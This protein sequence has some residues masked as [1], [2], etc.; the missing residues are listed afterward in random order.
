MIV[1]AS[2]RAITLFH[3]GALAL[4]QV[5][6][7][8]IRVDEA[9]LAKSISRTEKKIRG[10]KE[11]LF[12][13]PIYKKWK[14]RFGQST[15]LDAPEQLAKIIFEDM[16]YKPVKA[17]TTEGRYKADAEAFEHVDEPFVRDLF[18]YKRLQKALT[19]NLRGL[20]REVVDGLVHAI[21]NLN[22]PVSFRSSCDSPNVQNQPVRNEDI[23]NL[24]RHCFIARPG[25]R[26][27][28]IDYGKI[29]VVV[30]ACYT[31]DPILMAEVT[32]PTADMHRDTAMQ[33]F[34]LKKN[35]INKAIRQTAKNAYVF[36]Q[37]YGSYY[38]ECAKNIWDDITR[39]KLATN[40]GILLKDHLLK[41][42]IKERGLCLKGDK[43]NRAPEP[44]KGTFEYH[45][46]DVD[47]DFWQ[48]R[49]KVY[50]Q[51]KKDWW[52]LYLQRT[53]FRMKTGFVC[54]GF[55]NRKQ[56]C[57]YPIQGSAFHCLLWSLIR[58]QKWLNR[59]KMKSK[60]LG[61]VHDSMLIEFH[62]REI[63]DVLVKAKQIM[64][65]DIREAWSWITVP[66]LV[67]AEIAPA[68]GSWADKKSVVIAA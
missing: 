2:K 50:S 21:Y 6:S 48:R 49:F 46:K 26:I 56:V 12:Q 39:Y 47:A 10:M 25:Y 9:Y 68:G 43:D 64:T 13:D 27:G 42:G 45:L 34:K 57:N 62:K 4:S 3:E 51:W 52:N 28:E 59:N 40:S 32:D 29:E 53:W 22:V 41:Q 63:D 66:L 16:G 65:E 36:P 44:K 31:G 30:A 14:R 7:N 17:S 11:K 54:Q 23:G 61:Q 38:A 24:I 1:P 67:E 33:I 19:T 8:G 55:I 58:L 37:F 18:E 20:Q 35:D 15:K 5:E 60:I